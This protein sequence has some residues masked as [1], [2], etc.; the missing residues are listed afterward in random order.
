MPDRTTKVTLTA[1]V[2]GYL[3]G[4]DQAA[5]K[6]REFADGS[7]Q[8]LAA[9]RQAMNTVGVAMV[10]VGAAAAAG[11]ALAVKAWA[12]FDAKMAQ[13]QTLSHATAD[14][15]DHLRDSALHMGQAIGFSATQVADAEIEL[16][17]AGVSVKDIM[18]GALAGSLHLAAAGQIDVAQ[19]TEIATIA[20]TQFGLKGKDVPHVADLLTAG[21]DKALGGVSDLGEALKSGGLVASQFGVSLD[22]TIGTL[23][24]FANAGLLGET[25]GTDLRQMLLKLANPSASAADELKKLGINI[26]DTNGQF[27]GMSGLAGQLSTKLGGVDAATRNAALAT[28]F[29]SRAIAGANVLYKEGAKGISDWTDNVNDQGF[30][31]QQAAGKMNNLKGDVSKLTAAFNTGLIQ[32]GSTV[33]G[34]LRGIVQA[35]TNLISLF[36]ELPRP[37]QGGALAVGAVVAVVGLLGGTALLV[38]PKIAAFKAA[39]A[40]LSITMRGVSLAGG[41]VAIAITAAV[42]VLSMLAGANAEAKQ[43][44]QDLSD[45]FDKQTG[46]IT[47][48]TRAYVADKLQKEGAIKAA[49]ALGIS[50]KDLVDAY[51]QQPAA[52]ARVNKALKDFQESQNGAH[53]ESKNL[54]GSLTELWQAASKTAKALDEGAPATKEAKERFAEMAAATATSADE[55]LSAADAYKQ[56]ASNAQGLDDQLSSLIDTINKANGVGQD[57]VSTNNAYQQALADADDQVKKAKAGVKGYGLGLDAATDAGRKNTDMLVGLAKKNEDAAK[58]QFAADGDSKNYIATLT[59]G[60]QAIV[61]HA[62]ALGATAEQAQAIA[63]KVAAI[64]SE[65]QVQIIADTANAAKTID[66]FIA[67]MGQKVGT[68]TFRSNLSDLNGKV[69]GTGRMGT[70]GSGGYTGDMPPTAVAGLVHGREF[71]NDEESTAKP[72]NRAAME[73]MN[74]GGDIR[75]WSSKAFVPAPQ[76][77]SAPQYMTASST[78]PSGPVNHWQINEVSDPIGTA[79][80]VIRRQSMLGA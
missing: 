6:T 2:S 51:L 49:I 77:M 17:K 21:A 19:A 66:D 47:K 79:N 32:A 34:V 45:T 40:E 57:A 54:G 13:V 65:K 63:D 75:N 58:A 10:A 74:A 33:D 55:G 36:D 42:T 4:M 25:A 20:L 68:I 35:G 12:D 31:A 28:I 72:S 46:A 5:R 27:V 24:A 15:M 71:V 52:L 16:V 59:A 37:V 9:Q 3:N 70:F 67:E 29:G 26:Y 23:S 11:V 43:T 41:A 18:G 64:P 78:A 50:A 38:V 53:K 39:L 61:D 44:A 62:L 76:Y 1:V 60:H 22:E 73:F 7:A 56:A 69:S 48:N 14:E 80:A 30:A 8:K